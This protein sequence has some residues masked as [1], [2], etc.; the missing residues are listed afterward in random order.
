MSQSAVQ[1]QQAT[2]FLM[3]GDFTAALTASQ[4][5]VN[6]GNSANEQAKAHV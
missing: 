6:L 4:S 1:V 2:Q 5:A 3:S